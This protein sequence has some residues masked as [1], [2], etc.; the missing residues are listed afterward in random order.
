[1]RHSM[2]TAVTLFA[3]GCAV[4]SMFA[5]PGI[6]GVRAGDLALRLVRST[7]APLPAADM[8]RAAAEYLAAR[9]IV[10][11]ESL[12]S[13]VL[14]RDV[15]AAAKIA[16]AR[17]LSSRPASPITPA[18]AAA[19]IATMRGVVSGDLPSFG[20]G[21]VKEGDI[22]ASCRGRLARAGRKGTPASPAN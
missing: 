16:G 9:G 22:N 3:I 2:K 17:V 8:E 10:F 11:G 15:V 4:G 1:M 13:I 19:F 5:A 21:G 14:E 20:Q 18:Q 6:G 12:D 7:G